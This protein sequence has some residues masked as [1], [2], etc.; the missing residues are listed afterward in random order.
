MK[1]KV[2]LKLSIWQ[3]YMCLSIT[4]LVLINIICNSSLLYGTCLQH[5]GY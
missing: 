5:I 4:D 1:D 2:Q 3:E